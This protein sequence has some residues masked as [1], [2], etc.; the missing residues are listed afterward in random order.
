MDRYALATS[1]NRMLAAL[2]PA[3]HDRVQRHLAGVSPQLGTVLQE[4]YAPIEHVYFP[5]DGLLSLVV[6]M[7]EG[8]AVETGI[9]GNEGVDGTMLVLGVAHA[10]TSTTVQVAGRFLR[11]PAAEFAAAFRECPT[12]AVL[13]QRYH[14]ALFFQAKQLIACNA[15]HGAEMRLARWMLQVRDRID[16]ARLP[17]THEFLAQMLAVRR[18]TVTE[19]LGEFQARGL[20]RQHRG[21][22][23]LLDEARLRDVACECYSA[24]RDQQ[25]HVL[26]NVPVPA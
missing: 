1:Q 5:V 2:P 26:P 3:E 20:V 7:R 10:F 11:M 22:I 25:R 19:V 18:T 17:L 4:V 6:R 15:I 8:D 16:S 12:L 13:T 14:A 9:I 21:A 24:I 23:E